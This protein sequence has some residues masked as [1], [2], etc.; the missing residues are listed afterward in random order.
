ML[1]PYCN[2]EL[3][4]KPNVIGNVNAYGSTPLIPASCCGKGIRIR[5]E[6][7]YSAVPSYGP[8]RMSDWDDD[9]KE[10]IPPWKKTNI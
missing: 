7:T 8:D 6:I 5:G 3:D 2:S 4:I 9:I 10:S 1:C